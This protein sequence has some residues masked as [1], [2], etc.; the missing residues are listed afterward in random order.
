[1]RRTGTDHLP[2]TAA[3]LAAAVFAIAAPGCSGSRGAAPGVEGKT[4]AFIPG[5]INFDMEVA[6]VW[7]DTI[8]AIEIT[9]AIPPSS[10]AFLRRE[11]NF[12]ALFDVT[13]RATEVD[14]KAPALERTWPESLRVAEYDE[15]QKFTP[16]VFSRRLPLRPGNYVADVSV[17]DRGSGRREM[18]SERL[19]IPRLG[20]A[21]PTLGRIFIDRGSEGRW[22]PF[23]SF[24][25]PSGPDSL[26]AT[27]EGYNLPVGDSLESHAIVLKYRVDTSIAAPPFIVRGFS[28]DMTSSNL[29]IKG[30]DTVF[31]S[32]RS[33]V[34]TGPRLPVTLRLPSLA[35]GLYQLEISMHFR[36]APGADVDSVMRASRLFPVRAFGFPRPVFLDDLIASMRYMMTSAEAEQV[37]SGPVPAER[38]RRFEVF[39]RSLGGDRAT[40]AAMIRRYFS[41]VEEAN[42]YFTTTKE[43]WK[44]DRGMISIVFGPPPEAQRSPD[45]VAWVY[46][47]GTMTDIFFFRNVV[48]DV[49]DTSFDE[50]VLVRQA[51]YETPWNRMI[52]RLRKN[53]LP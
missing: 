35:P 37:Q 29:G 43:G 50:Y 45:G 6:P 25:I 10:L 22:S 49:G 39:W 20:A 15:T 18:R 51:Y 19:V 24:N 23:I 9:L 33:F 16:A 31:R 48:V 26:R 47:R 2:V 7:M 28:I 5:R 42:R 53:E 41:R 38:L 44:T 1:M 32:D 46:G 21:P 12:S 30:V 3:F 40:A 34:A 13:V 36:G 27:L 17:E 4:I 14:S 8:S 11:D 52:T